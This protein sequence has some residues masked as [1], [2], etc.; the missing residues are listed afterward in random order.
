MPKQTSWSFR[1]IACRLCFVIQVP[2][3]IHDVDLRAR[4]RKN[5]V[6]ETSQ[7]I[8]TTPR[9]RCEGLSSSSPLL[10]VCRMSRYFAKPTER[11]TTTQA[12]HKTKHE[13]SKAMRHRSLGKPTPWITKESQRQ[14]QKLREPRPTYT[15][16]RSWR[17][18]ASLIRGEERSMAPST[19]SPPTPLMSETLYRD[20]N[21]LSSFENCCG[22]TKT[23]T[24]NRQLYTGIKP[25]ILHTRVRVAW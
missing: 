4:L 18:A 13:R 20:A 17:P 21:T 22:Q 8:K 7:T 19:H 1:Q 23:Q 16:Y 5:A 6:L 11:Q 24:L 2:I 25:A 9:T 14:G 12:S 3:Q 10:A 15:A